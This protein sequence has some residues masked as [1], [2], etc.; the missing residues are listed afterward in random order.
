[1]LKKI[2]I[3]SQILLVVFCLGMFLQKAHAK[4]EK[5][6]LCIMATGKYTQYAEQ[7][8]RS[9]RE[10]FLKEHDITYIVFTDGEM[11]DAEDVK[12]F[13]QKRLGWPHD[14][15]MRFEVYLNQREYL[16]NFDYLF[17]IDADMLFVSEVG[18]EVLDDLIGTQ[19]PGFYNKRGSYE[20]RRRSTAC[21]KDNEGAY[22][23]AGGFYGGKKENF[24]NL[25]SKTSENIRKDFKRKLI[26]VWHDESHLNRYF[27]DHPPTRILDP[28]YCYPENLDLPFCRKLLALDKNH[29]E[30]RK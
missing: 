9:G 11:N 1:M 27:I 29:N 20:N 14:T 18:E 8:I 17:G 12:V 19:H 30:L 15:L 6:A 2:K 28:S 23:F 5:V 13:Y 16:E 3:Q 10:F 25:L 22:Y 21:V 7:L 4:E 24:L 26:A